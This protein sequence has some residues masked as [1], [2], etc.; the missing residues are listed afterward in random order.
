[1]NRDTDDL[2]VRVFIGHPT[3]AALLS[4]LLEFAQVPTHLTGSACG[5]EAALYVRR[6]D[7][8]AAR[9]IVADR[10]RRR[11]DRR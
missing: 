10:E 6:S 2:S 5:A 8:A 1:M 7:E 11:E 4:S 3:E 9:A